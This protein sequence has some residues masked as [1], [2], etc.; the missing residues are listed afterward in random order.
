MNPVITLIFSCSVF[1]L[2]KM[3]TIKSIIENPSLNYLVILIVRRGCFG[4]VNL[5]MAD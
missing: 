2:D 1:R 4:I 5:A 3:I